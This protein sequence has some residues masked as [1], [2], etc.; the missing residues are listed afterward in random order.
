MKPVWLSSANEIIND[1]NLLANT[2][3]TIL[4]MLFKKAIGL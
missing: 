3:D 1:N 4:N 2:L